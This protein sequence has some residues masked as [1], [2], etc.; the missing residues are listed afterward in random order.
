M[1]QRLHESLLG[2]PGGKGCAW[3]VGTRLATGAVQAMQGAWI[4]LQA[5]EKP[6]EGSRQREIC[7]L[8]FLLTERA[9]L[10]RAG[11]RGPRLSAAGPWERLTLSLKATSLASSG[12]PAH[13]HG[14]QLPPRV[15]HL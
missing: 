8:C 14:T 5:G 1:A 12:R 3:K 13:L 6:W 4:L 7:S 9:A 2:P 11:Q 15:L 10:S